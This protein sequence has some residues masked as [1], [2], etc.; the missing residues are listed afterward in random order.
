MPTCSGRRGLTIDPARRSQMQAPEGPGKARA[1]K[2][3]VHR[4]SRREDSLDGQRV[5]A[6]AQSGH[7]LVRYKYALG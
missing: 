7:G 2:E 6:M 5:L 3:V 1:F 4:A